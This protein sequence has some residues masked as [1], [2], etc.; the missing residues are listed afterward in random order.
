MASDDELKS[1]IGLLEQSLINVERWQF[2]KRTLLWG[3]GTRISKLEKHCGVSNDI[4]LDNLDVKDAPPVFTADLADGAPRYEDD[5]RPRL[6]APAPAQMTPTSS[7]MG[8][9]AQ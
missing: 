2:D 8:T 5:T 1:R 6:P 7:P 9:G 3:F 4:V